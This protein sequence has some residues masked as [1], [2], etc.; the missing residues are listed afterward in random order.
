MGEYA[1]YQGEDVKIGTCEDMYYLRFEQRRLVNFIT[2]NVD[3]KDY[4]TVLG[5]RFRFP[6]PDE[7]NIEP[8]GFEDSDRSVWIPGATIPEGVDHGTVQFS[9]PGYNCSLPC[10]E[11]GGEPSVKVFR[12]GFGGAVRL[13]RQ[14]L[15]AD[16]R[17]VPI[18]KCGGCGHLWR[19]EDDAE[20]EE[21]ATLLRAEGQRRKNDRWTASGERVGHRWWNEIADRMLAGAGIVSKHILAQA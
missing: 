13:V 7:D 19:S 11:S 17:L 12:N 9:A 14:K 5:L 6:W 21:L 4:Q 3:V 16:G 15:L 20:I 10:P 18:L 1:S 8:G 2:G